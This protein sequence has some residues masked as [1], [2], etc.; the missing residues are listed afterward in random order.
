[1]EIMNLSELRKS[2]LATLLALVLAAMLVG[3]ASTSESEP[4]SETDS[5]CG[6]AEN[7]LQCKEE[8]LQELPI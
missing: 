4:S 3:C 1:M 2:L 8:C 7:D 6:C 5:D